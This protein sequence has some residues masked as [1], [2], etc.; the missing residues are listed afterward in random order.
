MS[1]KDVAGTRFRA[2]PVWGPQ[3]VRPLVLDAVLDGAVWTLIHSLHQSILLGVPEGE[4]RLAAEWKRVGQSPAQVLGRQRW[5]HERA[6]A[7][8]ARALQQRVSAREALRVVAIGASWIESRTRIAGLSVSPHREAL[9]ASH[10]ATSGA[11][12][13]ERMK[14]VAALGGAV[15]AGAKLIAGACACGVVTLAIAAAVLGTGDLRVA[16]AAL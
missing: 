4:G 10:T 11:L 8:A 2:R 15:I 3:G 12:F 6:V 16:E 7:R 9:E 13:A 14:A 5:I 1:A